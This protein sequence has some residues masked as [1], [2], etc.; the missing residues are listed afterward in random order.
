M[1]DHRELDEEQ[2]NAIAKLKQ[3]IS[4]AIDSAKV[5]GHVIGTDGPAAEAAENCLEY[6]EIAYSSIVYSK[7]AHNH[8]RGNPDTTMPKKHSSKEISMSDIRKVAERVLGKEY[9]S[10]EEVA[11]SLDRVYVYLNETW[12]KMDLEIYSDD[13]RRHLQEARDRKSVV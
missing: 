6:L 7:S 3:L 11:A 10:P 4:R 2:H 9:M 5:I 12:D 13:V 8:L 1:I